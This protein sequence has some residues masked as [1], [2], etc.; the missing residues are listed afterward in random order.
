MTEWKEWTQRHGSAMRE[1]RQRRSE[2]QKYGGGHPT[3]D[4]TEAIAEAIESLSAAVGKLMGEMRDRKTADDLRKTPNT[5][6][7]PGL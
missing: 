4:Y 6:E 1:F 3:G 5:E 7:T 2:H